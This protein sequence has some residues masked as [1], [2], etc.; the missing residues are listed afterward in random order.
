M[1][2]EGLHADRDRAESFG[3][4]ADVY[5][6][7]RP[8]YPDA[9]IDDLLAGDPK[10]AL[11]IGC[12]TGKAARPLASRGVQ[13]LG[14]EPDARMAAI[15]RDHEIDVEIGR[16]EDWDPAGRSFDLVVSGQ[17]WH[18]VDPVIGPAKVLEVLRSGGLMSTFWNVATLAP[19]VRTDLDA[20]YE[21]LA[22]E[23]DP[24][25]VVRGCG[26]VVRP[27][28]PVAF[29]LPGFAPLEYGRYEWEQLY[30]R[31]AWVELIATHS[32]HGMLPEATRRPLLAAVGDVIDLHAGEVT[33]SYITYAVFA[34][35]G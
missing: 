31:E 7:A 32:D 17:A 14:V 9:L 11:D 26:R 13:V 2:N 23:V 20:V 34:H 12:G 22:P 28:A 4:G 19:D 24:Y 6:R 25:S 35:A 1:T 30:S 16:F 29:E 10:L 18:W 5:D 15:A 8:G 3:S 27:E 33:A 21:R